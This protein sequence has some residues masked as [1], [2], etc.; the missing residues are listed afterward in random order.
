[1]DNKVKVLSV[2]TSDSSGG[3]ARAAYR[4]YQAVKPFDVDSRMFVKDKGTSEEDIYALRDFLPTNPFYR[5][6]DCARN[7]IKN[8]W[9]HFIWGRYPNREHYYMSDLRSTNI[10][11]ALERLDY[12]ILHL[13]WIN[14]RFLPLGSLP[15]GKPIIW[16]LHDT[17]PF[18]GICHYFNECQGYRQSCG[19]CP[20]LK[21]HRL[22][23]LSHKIW[24]R[25]NEIYKRLNLQIVAPSSWMG[26]CAA[27][28]GLLSQ[29]QTTV[30]PNCIDPLEY[31]PLTSHEMSD[32]WHDLVAR[33]NR[34]KFV[35]YGAMNAT[36]DKRKGYSYL[37]SALEQ[38]TDDRENNDIELVV[39]GANL[40]LGSSPIGLP[41]HFVGFVSDIH[42]LVS[43][44]SLADVMVVPSLN[45]N[46]SCVIMESLACETPVVAFDI[47]GN[48]DM[49]DHQENGYLAKEK[50]SEDFAN[51]I[52]WCLENNMDGHLSQNARKKVLENYTPEV[53]GRQYAELY[54][55]LLKQ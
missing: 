12:D 53:V 40:S 20:Q 48:G 21:S 23:D 19:N 35:L 4:I 16:T 11:G 36:V 37:I 42:E 17:W 30:I 39:F 3:A 50:D 29:F 44:Y 33:K 49:I 26:Q 9:Q 8:K 34:K 10:Q 6:F 28:S 7:K 22:N 32:R 55:S 2:C 25:K 14:Q 41:T 24:R 46:L 27:E 43:L 51:G 45:E 38:I 31:K 47:G 5:F 15:E 13:H 18:C 52:L 1:M 54:S